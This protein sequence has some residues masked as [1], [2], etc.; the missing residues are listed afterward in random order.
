MR[1]GHTQRKDLDIAQ[2]AKSFSVSINNVRGK[3]NL[4]Q[5]SRCNKSSDG[6]EPMERRMFYLANKIGMEYLV[7]WLLSTQWH[8]L[9]HVP[10]TIMLLK[11]IQ[12]TFWYLQMVVLLALISNCFWFEVYIYEWIMLSSIVDFLLYA[13]LFPIAMLFPCK[14]LAKPIEKLTANFYRLNRDGS[15]IE[16]LNVLFF[17]PDQQSLLVIFA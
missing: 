17:D 8:C 1:C 14:F 11:L 16:S 12:I 6:T 13:C 5:P 3:K 9:F 15:H 10:Q 2:Y 7:V 4:K